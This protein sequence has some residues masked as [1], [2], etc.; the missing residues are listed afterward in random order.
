[1]MCRPFKHLYKII[2]SIAAQMLGQ[3]IGGVF[4][5]LVDICIVSLNV[6]EEDVGSVCFAIATVVLFSCM[7]SLIW[8]LRTP[9]F[10]F[11]YETRYHSCI[12]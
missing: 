11:Y 8:A 9:F 5:A 2:S 1:M 12:T 7:A 6:K 4:P 10:K 3:A